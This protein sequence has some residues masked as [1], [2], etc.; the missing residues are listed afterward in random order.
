MTPEESHLFRLVIYAELTSVE[1]R[2]IKTTQ[3]IL[4]YLQVLGN[5]MIKNICIMSDGEFKLA[6]D[7]LDTIHAHQQ[8]TLEILEKRWI[9]HNK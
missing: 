9:E 6:K 5:Q 1:S 7:V 2:Y 3:N 4:D 8:K